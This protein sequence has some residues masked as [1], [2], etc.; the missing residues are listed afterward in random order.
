LHLLLSLRARNPRN[1]KA[2]PLL[3]LHFPTLIGNSDMIDRVLAIL[4][5]SPSLLITHFYARD[6]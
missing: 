2:L 3:T 4:D 5:R 6:Y 1:I